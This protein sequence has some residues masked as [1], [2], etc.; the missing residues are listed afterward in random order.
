MPL[1]D[2]SKNSEHTRRKVDKAH[3]VYLDLA[4]W[5]CFALIVLLLCVVRASR[6]SLEAIGGAPH[7]WLQKWIPEA[8]FHIY[9]N[10][11]GWFVIVA[12]AVSL[13]VVSL[14]SKIFRGGS[15]TREETKSRRPPARWALLLGVSLACSILAL[16]LALAGEVAPSGTL[17]ILR[18]ASLALIGGAAAFSLLSQD[19]QTPLYPTVWVASAWLFFPVVVALALYIP[20]FNSWKFIFIGDEY[21]FYDLASQINDNGFLSRDLL[22]GAGVFDDHPMLLSVWQALFFRLFE[23]SNFTWRLS[24]TILTLSCVL[25]L[26]YLS[27]YILP[28]KTSGSVRAVAAT[29]AVSSFLFSELISV[30]SIIGKPHVAFLPPM[31]W[32]VFFLVRAHRYQRDR[33]FLLSGVIAGTGALFSPLAAVYAVSSCMAVLLLL[34]FAGDA[35]P[36]SQPIRTLAYRLLVFSFGVSIAA[37]PILVQRD[38]LDHLFN[39]NLSNDDS[40]TLSAVLHRTFLTAFSFTYFNAGSHYLAWN[41]VDP[42][43]SGLILLGVTKALFWRSVYTKIPLVLNFVLAFTSGGIGYYSYPSVTRIHVMEVP[44]AFFAGLGTA[45]LIRHGS[46][47]RS[48]AALFLI[49]SIAFYNHTKLHHFNPFDRPIHFV[50]HLFQ[51]IES[52]PPQT[53]LVFIFSDQTSP[54]LFEHLVRLHRVDHRVR[55]VSTGDFPCIFPEEVAFVEDLALH[56]LSTFNPPLSPDCLGSA[57]VVFRRYE[58]PCPSEFET[59]PWLGQLRKSTVNLI[60]ALEWPAPASDI[61]CGTRQENTPLKRT[62]KEG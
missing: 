24:C 53:P 23:A 39:K 61:E 4:V 10:G 19:S 28:E 36:P 9:P 38:Y 42:L 57:P 62:S 41:I 44:F 54:W 49:G 20:E 56:H 52:H 35:E 13:L 45:V 12:G 8:S 58:R 46:M 47:T 59:H 37:I 55:I 1:Q 18:I 21:P 30:W 17:S 3:A 2:A 43:R 32:S 16:G 51:K 14:S 60:G 11:L 29:A 7:P 40:F 34:A 31:V 25:P 5:S 50:H 22:E 27:Y 33:L 48:V 26:W 15:T 6:T